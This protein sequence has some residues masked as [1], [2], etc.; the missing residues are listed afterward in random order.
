MSGT[1]SGVGGTA[2][3]SPGGGQAGNS[4]CESGA[5]SPASGRSVEG[6]LLIVSPADAEAAQDVSEITGSL[7]ITTAFEGVLD[8]PN[9]VTVGGRVSISGGSSADGQSVVWPGITELRLPNLTSIG[10]ELYV[11]LTDALV[12][13]DLRSLTHVGYRVY[14]MRNLALERIGLDA[15]SYAD[16]S[17]QSCP[18]AAACEIDAICARVG[19][20]E[21]GR[22][23]SDPDCTCNERC[24]RTE[25]SCP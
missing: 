6:D 4:E 20:T 1:S 17:I 3:G 21:C 13:T 19:Q 15:L 5:D 25:S 14:Y 2:A 24:G 10:D 8:L 23:Y 22:V 12:E 9:L 16:V 18:V 11:Y 7:E